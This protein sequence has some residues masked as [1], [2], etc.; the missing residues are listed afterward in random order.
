MSIIL[1]RSDGRDMRVNVWNWGVL[2]HLVAEAALFSAAV[3]EPKRFNGGGDLGVQEV[4]ALADFLTER[5]LPRL[6]EGERIF[7]DGTVTDVPDD[8]AF[9]REEAD[10]WRNY[11][12]HREVLVAII[13]FLR[14][15][16]PVTF[17]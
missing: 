6:R 2:H 9:Y 17:H 5:L 11:S 3:W 8:G 7:L 13:E 1:E 15:G 14:T 4:A 12:L 10:L 16:G